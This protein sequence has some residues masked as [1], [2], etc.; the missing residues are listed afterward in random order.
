M[1]QNEYVENVST[2]A[3]NSNYDKL[4]EYKPS[5]WLVMIGRTCTADLALLLFAGFFPNMYT[6]CLLSKYNIFEAF[7]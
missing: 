6:K 3:S 1:T 7:E 4:T 2:G 5:A